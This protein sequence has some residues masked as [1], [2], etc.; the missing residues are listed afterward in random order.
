MSKL[1]LV[2]AS[3]SPRRRQLLE[4]LGLPFEIATSDVDETP[5]PDEPD[6]D[7]VRRAAREKEAHGQI[8]Q[9]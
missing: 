4:L 8:R 5:R 6:L 2:L 7:Y 9:F 1:H 3:E